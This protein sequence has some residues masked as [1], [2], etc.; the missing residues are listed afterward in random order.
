MA[1]KD[2]ISPENMEV[3]GPRSNADLIP[4]AGK[5]KLGTFGS[6]WSTM[7]DVC[8]WSQATHDDQMVLTNV[9]F[10]FVFFRPCAALG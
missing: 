3:K 5:V 6:T 8:G 4:D 7:D 10:C 2:D 1:P 9:Q